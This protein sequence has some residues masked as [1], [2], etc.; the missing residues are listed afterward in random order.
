MKYYLS[1]F[2]KGLFKPKSSQE[3]KWNSSIQTIRERVWRGSKVSPFGANVAFI[4]YNCGDDY[5]V[6]YYYISRHIKDA[7][8][9]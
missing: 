3:M 9:C 2:F 5:K 8:R 6:C 7:L 1:N 4:L